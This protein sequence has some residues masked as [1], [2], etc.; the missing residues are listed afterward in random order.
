MTDYGSLLAVLAGHRVRFVLVGGA[1]AIV[2]G[3]SRLTQVVDVVYDRSEDNLENLV[4]ALKAHR[5]YLRGAPEGLPF[6]WSVA[7]LKNGLN[8]TL[9]CDLGALDL[10]GEI[11]GGGTYASLAARSATVEAMGVSFLCVNLDALIETKRAAGRAKDLEALA[12]LQEIKRL[13]GSQGASR[14][15]APLPAARTGR[16]GDQSE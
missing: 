2:H 12:E 3:A 11:A 8:F 6:E 15:L 5:P 13:R 16:D 4:E 1:A 14:I 9:I 7:T 10:F